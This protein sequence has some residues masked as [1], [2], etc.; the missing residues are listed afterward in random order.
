MKEIDPNILN[1]LSNGEK[2]V[3]CFE[4]IKNNKR[5]F[6]T[7]HSK[8]LIL[9]HNIY[10]HYSGLT[11]ENLAFNDSGKDNIELI[12][13]FESNGITEE[14]DLTGSTVKIDILFLRLN[15]KYHF[16][17]CFCSHMIKNSLYFKM[18]LEPISYKLQKTIIESYGIYCR[19][20]LGDDRCLVD[21]NLYEQNT[22]C[23][24]KFITCC[25]KFN[26]AV[27]FRGEPFIPE[28]T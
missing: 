9:S 24:K 1:A 11:I 16:A 12:G 15:E 6:F 21:K 5:L 10:L 25:N 20:N 14:E 28:I 27:N 4:I 17:E 13:I 23:D 26:N 18:I 19:A 22:S 3:Y 2:F 7:S 8:Q